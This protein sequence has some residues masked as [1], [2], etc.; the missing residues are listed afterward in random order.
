MKFPWLNF[1]PFFLGSILLS[2]ALFIISCDSDD[3]NKQAVC[4]ISTVKGISRGPRSIVTEDYVY[5]AENKI[6]SILFH[7][8]RWQAKREFQYNDKGL[9]VKVVDAQLSDPQETTVYQ[10]IYEGNDKPKEMHEW[11]PGVDLS[12]P[13]T[14]VSTFSHDEKNRLVKIQIP[15]GTMPFT[16]F[17]YDHQDNVTKMLYGDMTKESLYLENLSFDTKSKYYTLARELEILYV[18]V[19][20]IQPGI[21]NPLTARLYPLNGAGPFDITYNITYDQDG[22][23][24]SNEASQSPYTY[25]FNPEFDGITYICK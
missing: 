5:N 13:A 3:D 10:L 16:R 9:L 15:Y 12:R 1:L 6:E 20:R 7:G 8:D 18:Y 14:S 11:A 25:T 24:I 4:H 23:I 19:Y 17:E 22:R 21:N 2:S